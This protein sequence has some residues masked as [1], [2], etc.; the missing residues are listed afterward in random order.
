MKPLILIATLLL[1]SLANAQTARD[2]AISQTNIILETSTGK[3]FGTLCVPS[4]VKKKIPVVLIISGSGPTDRNCNS[5]LGL[6]CN[7]FKILADSLLQYGIASVRYDKRGVG[8][9]KT[10]M[11]KEVDLRFEDYVNDAIGFVTLLKK[12][13]RFSSVI[14]LGHS[15]G[16]LVGMLAAQQTKTN[17]YISVAGP[18]LAL[19][20]VLK[21][22]ISAQSKE[23]QAMCYPIIDS[24]ADGHLVKNINPILYTSFRPSVQPYIISIFKY[25]PATEIAKLTIPVAIIQGST[26]IQVSEEDGETLFNANNKNQYTV[27]KGMSHILKEGPADRAK[28]YATYNNPTSPILS[29]FVQCVVKFIKK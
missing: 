9:S 24:L 21:K 13:K 17:K 27:I 16:S 4:I 29:S 6:T 5:S 25:N 3:L 26:D 23:I 19:Q 15:E 11:G 8:E 14:I 7:S 28:N 2:T 10:A 22:Q 1:A 20:A 12:D 18:G